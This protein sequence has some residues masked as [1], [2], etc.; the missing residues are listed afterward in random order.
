MQ[1]G[2]LALGG[3][4]RAHR[5]QTE[6]RNRPS[7]RRR[8]NLLSAGQ[9]SRD[10]YSFRSRSFF[11]FLCNLFTFLVVGWSACPKTQFHAARMQRT[12][13]RLR[14]TT[15][16][17]T[18]SGNEERSATSPADTRAHAV[19][20]CGN[21]EFAEW[22]KNSG[23]NAARSNATGW[24]LRRENSGFRRIL[25]TITKYRATDNFVRASSVAPA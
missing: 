24:Q 23:P 19:S 15:N 1:R 3:S 22:R 5:G 4:F 25:K 8:L 7:L 6:V 10:G 17:S 12:P 16:E 13:T 9:S 18:K 20:N 11:L 14:A 21:L 2:Q